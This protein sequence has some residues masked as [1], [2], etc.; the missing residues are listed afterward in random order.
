MCFKYVTNFM[1]FV[2]LV[3]FFIG[4][5]D[6]AATTSPTPAQP[7]QSSA[8]N[9]YEELIANAVC[10]E[11]V[12]GTVAYTALENA[13]FICAVD[14]TAGVWVWTLVQENIPQTDQPVQP[15]NDISQKCPNGI[16]ADGS[17][18]NGLPS[19]ASSQFSSSSTS[20]EPP[21]IPSSSVSNETKKLGSITDV[22]DGQTYHTTTI[23]NS[24]TATGSQVWMAENLNYATEN[25]SCYEDITGNCNKYGRLY[26]FDAAV[27]ACPNGWHL[28]TLE[29]FN[30]MIT[31]A[32]GEM[33][34]GIQLKSVGA[35]ET[36]WGESDIY[37]FS[38]LP[39]G[40]WNGMSYRDEGTNA[41]FWT[42]T[43]YADLAYCI[44]IPDLS[45]SAYPDRCITSNRYSVRCI[46]D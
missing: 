45:T 17:C 7:Q 42:S 11:N 46:K 5:S 20:S 19:D 36:D 24:T 3:V 41:Y 16:L 10:N 39:A 6:N 28:P 27:E 23:K 21:L 22:R 18:N 37:S 1:T 8:F 43:K 40:R 33:Y 32:G 29:E 9:S 12:N 30:T 13:N 44:T 14:A 26:T 38:A 25:S 34:A 4:C 31:A 2:G 35:W 15:R